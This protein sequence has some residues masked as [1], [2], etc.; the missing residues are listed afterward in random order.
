MSSTICIK[1]TLE[2]LFGPMFCGKSTELVRRLNIA[3]EMGLRVLYINHDNDDRSKEPFSTH[4]PA[5]TN[6]GKISAKKISDIEQLLTEAKNW[7]VIGVDEA[8]F[9]LGL[10]TVVPDLVEK[11]NIRVIVAGLVG[12]SE[13]REFGEILHLIPK[14]SKVD[15]LTSFCVS[16][17][18]EKKIVEPAMFTRRTIESKSQIQ[19]G[20]KESYQP[21][22]RNCYLAKKD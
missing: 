2:V 18:N 20:A 13:R 9:F 14:C 3:A 4:N 1:P 21:V 7:D 11:Y 6:I 22:C 8:Q 15:M 5:M 16:C 10:K 17:W 19:I 12:D